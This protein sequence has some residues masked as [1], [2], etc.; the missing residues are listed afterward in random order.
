MQKQ[1]RLIIV[2]AIVVL[3]VVGLV[4]GLRLSSSPSEEVMPPEEEAAMIEPATGDVEVDLK[5]VQAQM[6]AGD[7]AGARGA[8]EQAIAANPEDA[9]AYFMLGLTYFNLQAYDEAREAFAQSMALDPERS[10]A[11]H[12]N[13]GVLAYQIGDMETAVAEFETALEADPNDPDSH[14]QL[15]AAYLQMAS[16]TQDASLWA[17]A[18]A[19]F[20]QVLTLDP[21]KPEALVGLGT[22]Y[23]GQGKFVEAI[24][25]LEQA[26]DENPEM[27]E[28]LFALGLSYKENAQDDLAKAA[29]E[30][31]LE[32]EPPA[33]WAQ[34]AQQALNELTP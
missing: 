17:K 4:V 22:L 2:G 24:P 25:L 33:Q 13:L 9:E 29:L 15:G 5:V 3:V 14:Y 7:F 21:K 12:H 8:L 11:V 19:E 20:E 16:S 26:V 1:G 10:A 31:F 32:T 30:K 23:A 28:A 18:E 34:Q 6:D 27:R